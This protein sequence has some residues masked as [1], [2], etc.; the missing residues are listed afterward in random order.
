MSSFNLLGLGSQAAQANQAA[1]S[2]VGQNISNVNTPGYS[3]QVAN[4][5]TWPEQRG[6]NVDSITRITDDFL[7][8]QLWADTSVFNKTDIFADMSSQLDNLLA[9]DSTSLSTAM[10]NY[11]KALQNAVDDPTSLPNRELFVAEMEALARRFNDLNGNVIR[12]NE[13]VNDSLESL[14]Q[15][16]STIASEIANLNDKIR[17]EV[18]EGKTSNELRDQR[19]KLVADLSEL[20][21]VRVVEQ[22]HDEFAVFVSNGEP[23]VV[24]IS[25]NRLTTTVGDPDASQ[26]SVALIVAGNE[27][28]ITDRISGGKIG[29]LI[30]YRE[31]VLNPTINEL[32]RIGIGFSESMN[33][34]HQQGMDLEGNLGG[35]LFQDM[36]S[37][38]IMSNR[39]S[40]NNGNGSTVNSAYVN[41][42][43]I[44]TLTTSDYEITFNSSDE[45]FVERLS[46]GKR[47]SLLDLKQVDSPDALN[48]QTNAYYADFSQG[49]VK[50][51]FDGIQVNLDV[52][53]RFIGGDRFLVQPTRDAAAEFQTVVT[54]GR[55]L[56]LASPVR[57]LASP[58]NS[59]TGV[60]EINITD[61]DS[62]TFTSEAGVITPSVEVVFSAGSPTTFT[63][64][65]ITNPANPVPLEIDGIGPLENQIYTAGEPIQLDG[66]E[67]VIKNQPAAGDRFTF[68]Y[69]EDGVSDNRNALLMSGLQVKDLIDGGSFQDIY[70]SLIEEVGTQTSLSVIN[71][72]ASQSVLKSTQQS[73]SSLS[74]V[75]LDE[76]AAKLIQ[77]QQAYQASAQLISTS[78]KLFDSL[79]GAI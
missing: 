73:K 47:F 11:F 34:L 24:G 29:G 69:N 56:A 43:D 27:V 6:V 12:Q 9:T 68:E 21:D 33:E 53:N 36:N 44:S 7:T 63:V 66:Y 51:A 8:R 38:D 30:E 39:V 61:I 60:A 57:I 2:V 55:Q 52:T 37:S 5:A 48:G 70:G 31:T 62:T 74:G 78:Q 14:T 49:E 19:D 77:F 79:I 26:N 58:N 59:G 42:T 13:A 1:L 45:L 3:R 17:V 15:Q 75:N 35:L 10:D 67:I 54:D 23:L 71:R 28:E 18:A 40:A 64:Y 50:L 22:D 65:D 32:G 72:E 25:A 76:E 20:I 41:I 4:L 16:V 46:D